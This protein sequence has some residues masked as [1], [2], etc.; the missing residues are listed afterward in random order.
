MQADRSK[1]FIFKFEASMGKQARTYRWR[2]A[3]CNSKE[4]D[5]SQVTI[6]LKLSKQSETKS[7]EES[8]NESQADCDNRGRAD[9]RLLVVRQRTVAQTGEA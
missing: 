6:F 3:R 1:N 5:F 4:H 2:S 8:R 7:D 9:G